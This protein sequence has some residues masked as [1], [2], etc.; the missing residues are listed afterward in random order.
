MPCWAVT[1]HTRF[2]QDDLHFNSP[3]FL[4]YVSNSLFMLW[5]PWL[6]V[7]RAWSGKAPAPPSA[8]TPVATPSAGIPEDT[9]GLLAPTPSRLQHPAGSEL[10]TAKVALLIAGVWFAAQ[11]SYNW[12]LGESSV[13]TS[14]ILSNLSS[15]FTLSLAVSVLRKPLHGLHLVGVAA[16]VV[17]AVV[18]G[19]ASQGSG[20]SSALGF[21]LNL[22][23]AG[24]YGV[25][26]NMFNAWVPVDGPVSLR[27]VF[28][29]IG[30]IN[31]IALLPV[32][33]ALHWT[34]SLP[35]H[36]L[37]ASVFGWL[38]LKGLGD[39]VLSD[40][41]WAGA[42]QFI[43][44]TAS[45]VGIA[46]TIPMAMLGDWI[47]LH[48]APDVPTIAASLLVCAGF[49]IVNVPGTRLAPLNDTTRL[50]LPCLEGTARPSCFTPL[51][52]WVEG[53]LA[54]GAPSTPTGDAELGSAG[55]GVTLPTITLPAEVFR[56][57]PVPAGEPGVESS[58][59]EAPAR[60]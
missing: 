33:L 52:R 20:S 45:T 44:A 22:V 7:E 30:L 55:G 28:G 49:V 1:A 2:P 54:G 26:A 13:A 12:A 31:A 25:Y 35:L 10:Y 15:I 57:E 27:R 59:Q 43:G 24:M 34:G 21:L 5:L 6:A 50:R 58:Q 46:L 36:R 38:V 41:L 16:Q 17:G 8:A 48:K 37:S 56:P 32:L 51:V 14:T 3:F 9:R 47:V 53:P 19:V 4:T 40:L 29:Y 23:S 11:G 18:L 39:N 60:A 42:I